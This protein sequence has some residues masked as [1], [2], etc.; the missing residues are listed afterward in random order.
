MGGPLAMRRLTAEQY[1]RAVADVFGA[2]IKVAGRFEPD[3]RRD[4]LVAVGGSWST[5][6]PSS[7][8][9][10][11][12]RALSIAAQV[13]D[14]TH[15]AQFVACEPPPAGEADDACAAEFVR[16]I[17]RQLFRRPL[18][19]EEVE[20]RVAI[21]ANT[22]RATADFHAGLQ[23]ALASLLLAPEFL[24]RVEQGEPDPT[25]PQH[26][27]LT[28]GSVASRLSYFLWNTTPDEELLAATEGGQLLSDEAL[29]A[30][31]DR[32][33]ASPRL[34]EGM[35][36]FFADVY[37]FDDFEDV[38]KDTILYPAFSRTLLEDAQEQTL[39]VIIDHLI[40]QRGDFRDLFTTRKSF[41]TRTL[42]LV[43]GVP[44]ATR[45]GWEPFEFPEGS[46]RSGIYTHASLMALHSHPGRSSPTMRGIFV[47]EAIMCQPVSAAPADVT[48]S[49]VQ[50]TD[51]VEFKTGRERLLAHQTDKAC[52]KCHKVMDP[53]G[54]GLDN[55]DAI[56]AYRATENGVP[57]DTSGDVS[58]EEFSDTRDLGRVLHDHPAVPACLV[59]NLYRYAVGRDTALSERRLLRYLEGRF[60]ESGYR[61]H[62]LLRLIAM[63]DGFR[64]ASERRAVETQ[65]EDEV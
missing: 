52:A 48:F 23:F 16:G 5:T 64:T 6:T 53:I 15:R 46:L 19:E 32:L 34:E 3:A 49:V 65:P 43:Y 18:T 30:Q 63:S 1:K 8:E 50:E 29:G 17:G 62:D 47:R 54:L 36:A 41:M 37:S 14:E 39:R 24:F 45:D 21:A 10:S 11:E 40:S 42:G 35:R 13:V 9:Q 25:D 7:F 2:D 58:G 38:S 33:L 57:I 26:M 20:A 55:F 4:G 22:T 31:V 28:S 51:N 56:G 59:E 44:V 12:S 60:E 27:L 61:L